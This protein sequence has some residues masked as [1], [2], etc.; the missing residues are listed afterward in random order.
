[1]YHEAQKVGKGKVA[2]SP[3]SFPKVMV[4]EGT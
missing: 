2:V 3:G 4:S 1:M